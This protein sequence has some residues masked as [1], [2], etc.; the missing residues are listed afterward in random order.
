M[1]AALPV[2]AVE[3]VAAQRVQLLP[4]RAPEVLALAAVGAALDRPLNGVHRSLVREVRRREHIVEP[5]DAE[6]HRVA[7]GPAVQHEVEHQR[8]R[9]HRRREEVGVDGHG[10]AVVRAVAE[11][12]EVA[13]LAAVELVVLLAQ[14]ARLVA[15][16]EQAAQALLVRAVREVE[17]VVAVRQPEAR[18]VERPHALLEGVALLLVAQVVVDEQLHVRRLVAVRQ[19]LREDVHDVAARA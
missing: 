9:L 18:A 16:H 11:A 14:R 3:V 15:V 2:L 5:R 13:H 6:R 7:H 19:H 12:G 10:D 1:L 17:L 8:A 4:E